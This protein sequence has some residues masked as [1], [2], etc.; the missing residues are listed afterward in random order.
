[1]DS[2]GGKDMTETPKRKRGTGSKYE[3]HGVWWVKVSDR[4]KIYR[5][6]TGERGEKGETKADRLLV[7]YTEQ[8]EKGTFRPPTKPLEF[9]EM[10]A[11]LLQDYQV[12]ERRSLD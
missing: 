7:K 6:S 9:E 2:E 3:K 8:I 1:M 4:G 5:Q 11:L 10:A 12:N